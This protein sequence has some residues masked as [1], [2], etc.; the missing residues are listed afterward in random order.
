LTPGVNWVPGVAHAFVRIDASEAEPKSATADI[1]LEPAGTVRA[2]VVG[3]EGK[4]VRGYYVAGLT[5]SARD[6]VAWMTQKDSAAV[7]VRGLDGSRPRTVVALSA[8]KTLGA[9]RPVRVDEKGPIQVR[10]EPLGGVTGRV[11]DSDGRPRAGIPVRA[12]LSRTGDDGARL[13][14]QFFL[15]AGTWAGSLEP[16]AETDADGKFRLTEL[17][18]GL[19]YILVVGDEAGDVLQREGISPASGRV[20]DLG[21]IKGR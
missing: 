19:K 18:P 5:A 1:R 17:M 15:T 20:E 12:T 7:T 11:I 9:A 8:D 16:K 14:V 4:P 6:S 13:P 2:E 3:P 21:D 10:L